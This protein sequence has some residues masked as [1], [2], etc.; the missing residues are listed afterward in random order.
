MNTDDTQNTKYL[1]TGQEFDQESELYYYNARYYNPLIGRFISLDPI[2]GR[3]GDVLSRNGYIYV[4]NN[5][6]KYVDPSGETTKEI[7][8]MLAAQQKQFLEQAQQSSNSTPA[9]CLY[10]CGS[11]INPFVL[12]DLMPVSGDI[13][14]VY[15]L[16]TGS[17]LF[18]QSKLTPSQQDM[19]WAY[20]MAPALTAGQWR[21]VSK[22]EGEMEQKISKIMAEVPEKSLDRVIARLKGLSDRTQKIG[23]IFGFG[24]RTKGTYR[25]DSDVDIVVEVSNGLRDFISK[26]RNTNILKSIEQDFFNETGLKI[27]INPYSKLEIGP[28]TLFKWDDLFRL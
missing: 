14:D 25:T 10:N 12:F 2:L 8:A 28:K 27:D 5:P 24:S 7:Q 18:G 22:I 19:I 11:D 4:K 3:D 17:T 13:S 1:Y 26:E 16:Y 15:A 23:E 21:A 6:L 9:Y 20:A